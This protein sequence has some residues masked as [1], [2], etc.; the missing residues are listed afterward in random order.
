VIRTDGVCRVAPQLV[1]AVAGAVLNACGEVDLLNT[2]GLAT[3]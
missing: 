1:R 3:V 2:A